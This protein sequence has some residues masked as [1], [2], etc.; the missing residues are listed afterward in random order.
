MYI[1]RRFPFPSRRQIQHNSRKFHQRSWPLF[2][3]WLCSKYRERPAVIKLTRVY[4]LVVTFPQ[5]RKMAVMYRNF[6]FVA[7]MLKDFLI[8]FEHQSAVIYDRKIN[9]MRLSLVQRRKIHRTKPNEIRAIA[10]QRIAKWQCAMERTN[11]GKYRKCCA[12]QY[13]TWLLQAKCEPCTD[14]INS[15]VKSLILNSWLN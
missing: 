4:S 7:R 6:S 12:P 2:P 15:T 10:L 5:F 11:W 9:R 3:M 8:F 1:S 13:E 14:A